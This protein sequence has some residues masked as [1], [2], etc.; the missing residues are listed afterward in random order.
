[1]MYQNGS[2]NAR[3]RALQACDDEGGGQG[4]AGDV[5]VLD[6]VHA[7]L[8]LSAPPSP[9]YPDL[10]DIASVVSAAAAECGFASLPPTQGE[11]FLTGAA[12]VERV[13]TQGG[14]GSFVVPLQLQR[15]QQ[16]SS[17]AYAVIKLFYPLAAPDALEGRRLHIA[18]ASKD[19]GFSSVGQL[20]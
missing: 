3:A 9:S 17:S 4:L 12:L 15:L 5:S 16:Q 7:V 8:Y 14:V 20:V 11:K 6:L 19:F 18:F 1:M 13:M 2:R 10:S